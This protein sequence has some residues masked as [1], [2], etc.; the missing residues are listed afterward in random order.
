MPDSIDPFSDGAFDP[1]ADIYHPE[2]HERSAQPDAE[3]GGTE[4]T[5]SRPPLRPGSDEPSVP[6]SVD[7]PS[8]LDTSELETIDPEERDR[9]VLSSIVRFRF[10]T[11]GQLYHLLFQGSPRSRMRKRIARFVDAGA[12]TRWDGPGKMRRGPRYLLPTPATFRAVVEKIQTEIADV[13]YEPLVALMLPKRSRG[14]T[15]D[16]HASSPN[17]LQHQT[18]V[19]GLATRIVRSARAPLWASAWNV[20][21]PKEEGT[22]TL[23]QPDYVLVERDADGKLAIVFGEHDRGTGPVDRF[24]ARKIALYDD[25]AAYPDAAEELFGVPR[26][27]VDVT[28]LDRDHHRPMTRLTQFLEAAKSA[29]H[30]ELFRFTLGGW[31]HA[32]PVA[33]LWFTTESPPVHDAVGMDA[34]RAA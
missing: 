8:P 5:P 34:H 19:N 15:L 23:P 26:F 11:Y 9:K 13:S 32:Y 6:S 25:L 2:E 3:N 33:A 30:P 12:V 17:W 31:L 28:V 1:D 4:D 10:L 20:P 7:L 29:E 14:L 27:R 24:A 21:F 16:E 18:E 22:L